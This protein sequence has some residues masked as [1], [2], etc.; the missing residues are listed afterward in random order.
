M[1]PPSLTVPLAAGSYGVWIDADLAAAARAL[2]QQVGPRISGTALIVADANTSVHAPRVAQAWQEAGGN[3]VTAS[4]PAGESAKTL[5]QASELYSAL[6]RMPADRGTTVLAVGGGVVGDL[7]GFVAATYAR[8][9][10]WVVVPTSLLAMVDS[11]VG[12]KVGVNLP[13]GKN[14]VGAFHQPLAVWVCLDTLQ[15]LP[16]LEYRSGLAEVVKY[17][18]IAD[19]EFFAWLESHAPA[20]VARQPE[21]LRHAIRR[22]LEVKA[23]IVAAD[24]REE[25]DVRA[26]LNFGHTFG[27]AFE[28]LAH[29]SLRH[30]DAVAMGMMCAAR[31]AYQMNL[32]PPELV[33]RLAG[34]LTSLGLPTI[35]EPTWSVDQ[36]LT[37]MATDK[38][39]R[40]D[41]LRLILPRCLGQVEVFET[42]DLELLRE[43]IACSLDGETFRIT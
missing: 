36:L 20:L 35:P 19:A 43:R 41:R 21:A 30:G 38:K 6:A 32:C 2:R 42:T 10:P 25:I 28:T 9:L 34:L 26:R 4:I 40:A 15:T 29:F 3:V 17:G 1:L 7:A 18:V 31:L 37:A 5:G 23:A 27:H 22:S 14:L 11:A 39:R 8:G 24:V 13:E 33:T 12:G 16:D